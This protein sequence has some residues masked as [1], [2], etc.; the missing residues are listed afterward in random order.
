MN[1]TS[2]LWGLGEAGSAQKRGLF[3]EE[4]TTGSWGLGTL[5]HLWCTEPPHLKADGEEQWGGREECEDPSSAG[6]GAVVWWWAAG[7]GDAKGQRKNV[8]RSSSADRR[9]T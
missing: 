2:V 5:L 7:D 3:E 4:E 8:Q 9:E 1:K 6:T